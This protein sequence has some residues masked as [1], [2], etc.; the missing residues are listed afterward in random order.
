MAFQKI[1]ETSALL[2]R[3]HKPLLVR[4]TVMEGRTKKRVRASSVGD[5]YA[6]LLVEAVPLCIAVAAV[7]MQK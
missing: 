4:A 1:L 7:L 2:S 6:E 5:A 3:Q